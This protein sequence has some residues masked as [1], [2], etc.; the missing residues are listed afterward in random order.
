MEFYSYNSTKPLGKE[1]LGSNGRMITRDLKTLRGVEN[2]IP[3]SWHK[4][5]YS[6][7]TFTNFYNDDT[8]RLVRKVEPITHT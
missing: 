3:K 1:D 6:I 8:F 4:T 7:Y 5:G 2:R